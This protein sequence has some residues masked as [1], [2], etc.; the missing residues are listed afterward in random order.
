M[1]TSVEEK[2][3]ELENR[4]GRRYP[5]SEGYYGIMVGDRPA[6]HIHQMRKYT[7]DVYDKNDKYVSTFTAEHGEW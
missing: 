2:K 5:S 4:Y 7:F 3:Y 6:M 1:S